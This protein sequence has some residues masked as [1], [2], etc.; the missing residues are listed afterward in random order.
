MT[1]SSE[2]ETG[3]FDFLKCTQMDRVTASLFELLGSPCLPFLRR[4]GALGG[5]L[6]ILQ[7]GQA[8]C[9]ERPPPGAA[10]FV[11]LFDCELFMK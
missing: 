4:R 5:S 1:F 9:P 10:A 3:G 8:F 2:M 7:G 6:T 11:S